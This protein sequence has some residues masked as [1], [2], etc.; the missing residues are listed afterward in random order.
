RSGPFTVFKRVS[1]LTYFFNLPPEIVGIY[2]VILA[3]YF[4]ATLKGNNL[5]ERI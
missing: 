3:A 1:K 4:K 5:F 2:P